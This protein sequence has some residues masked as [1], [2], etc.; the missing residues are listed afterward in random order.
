MAV[1]NAWHL[2]SH[3]PLRSGVNLSSVAGS[4]KGADLAAIV[5][6]GI[7]E[8]AADQAHTKASCLKLRLALT[9][10]RGWGESRRA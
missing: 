8:Y 10:W 6:Y 1:Q 2:Q 9:A 5:L 3:Q 7:A 4:P